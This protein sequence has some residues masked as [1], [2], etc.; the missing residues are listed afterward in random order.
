[1]YTHSVKENANEIVMKLQE[2]FLCVPRP[3]ES[4]EE[5]ERYHHQ[6]IPSLGIEELRTELHVIKSMPRIASSKFPWFREREMK[7]EKA[8]RDAS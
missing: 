8:I 2:R 6:D 1:M 3:I 7:L 4:A 5:A